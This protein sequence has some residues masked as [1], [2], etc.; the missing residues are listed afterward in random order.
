MVEIEC[1]VLVL[2]CQLSDVG[3]GRLNSKE[4]G[5]CLVYC[6]DVC[7]FLRL[8]QGDGSSTE[9]LG[10]SIFCPHAELL[11]GPLFLWRECGGT[12]SVDWVAC[13]EG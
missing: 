12:V 4:T 11:P 7:Y 8:F 10:T 9:S 3:K 5:V 2:I 13:G 1:G 6:V